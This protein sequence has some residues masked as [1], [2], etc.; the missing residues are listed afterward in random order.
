MAGWMKPPAVGGG[1]L[2]GGCAGGGLC[3]RQQ[4]VSVCT[5]RASEQHG[6]MSELAATLMT[7]SSPSS[8]SLVVLGMGEGWRWV[9]KEGNWGMVPAALSA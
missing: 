1:K 9:Q 7:A 8:I 2:G 4:W 5:S 3:S 6:S